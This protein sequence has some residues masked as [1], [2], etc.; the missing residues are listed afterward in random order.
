MVRNRPDSTVRLSIAGPKK[1]LTKGIIGNVIYRTERGGPNVA[2]NRLR[3]SDASHTDLCHFFCRFPGSAGSA[4]C[5]D[6]VLARRPQS[7]HRAGG[8]SREAHADSVAIQ[9]S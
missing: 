3:F 6:R 9:Q 5:S 4:E 1:K 2:P 8:G 7:C